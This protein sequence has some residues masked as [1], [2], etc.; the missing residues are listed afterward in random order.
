MCVSFSIKDDR[1]LQAYFAV[2][3]VT[4]EVA[5]RYNLRP[6][7]QVPLLRQY[8]GKMHQDDAHW[9][10]IPA[11][12]NGTVNR[13]YPMFNARG[14]SLSQRS[15]YA[16]PFRSQRGILPMSLFVEQ[17]KHP[18]FSGPVSITDAEN[19]AL[20]VAALWDVWQ[21]GEQT[22]LSCTVVTTAAAPEFAPYHP[23]MPVMLTLAEC[24]RWL[25]NSRALP[26]DDPLLAPVLK[27]P[28]RLVPLGKSVNNVRDKSPETIKPMGEERLLENGKTHNK[29]TAP[30]DKRGRDT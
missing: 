28:L 11:H 24:E 19:E 29:R 9:W 13:K 8:G 26:A 30:Q 23:R 21:R 12:S 16:G 17:S 3:G 15:S 14:E 22:I 5:D 18:E 1:S 10:L 6:T 25:D 20:A 4:L 7:D 27:F 2:I